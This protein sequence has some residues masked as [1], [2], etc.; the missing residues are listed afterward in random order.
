MS[1]LIFIKSFD[2]NNDNNKN[3]LNNSNDSRIEVDN[4]IEPIDLTNQI[5][6]IDKITTFSDYRNYLLNFNMENIFWNGN[7]NKIYKDQ[8]SRR[9]EMLKFI[10]YL[11]YDEDHY[12]V[13]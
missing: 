12:S 1:D 10:K 2:E 7:R 11:K 5:N 6:K 8:I 13:I 4:I 3:K 9:K